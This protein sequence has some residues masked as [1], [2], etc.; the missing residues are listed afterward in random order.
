MRS[1]YHFYHICYLQP[2]TPMEQLQN[3][4]TSA[5]SR[6]IFP[7]K[8]DVT[9][10]TAAP[11]FTLGMTPK[12]GQFLYA[13]NISVI[14]SSYKSNQV[15]A[16]GAQDNGNLACFPSQF[17]RPM[18][19]ALSPRQE[20]LEIWVGCQSHLVRCCAAPSV[21][22]EATDQE[23][24]GGG[25]FTATLVPRQLHAT[26]AHDVHGIYPFIP[27]SPLYISTLFSALCQL[28]TTK[29]EE[30]AHVL[31]KPSFVSELRAEDRCHVNGVC[32]VRC[33]DG[34]QAHYATCLSE[35]DAFDGWRNHRIQ[36]GVVVDMRTNE[37]IVRGL[38]MPHSPSWHKE[39]L[40]LLNSGTGE[41]G[42]ID[43]DTRSFV[44][45]IFIPGF[46]RGLQFHGR[47]AIVGA[48]L[49]RHAERFQDLE[50]GKTLEKKKISATCGVY[51]V[52][53]A[54]WT[55]THLI[56]FTGGV[57]EIY[58]VLLVPGRRV[59]IMG[60]NDEEPKKWYNVTTT[61]HVNKEISE[62]EKH[63]DYKAPAHTGISTDVV[64]SVIDIQ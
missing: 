32:W 33:A 27:N 4:N 22:N 60:I 3:D 25:N 8:L 52:D 17:D 46:L 19:L 44:S 58:D 21:Y 61:E 53:M 47:Y 13:E 12:V 42:Y 37:I 55:I 15:F 49:S 63:S 62:K 50:L 5:P 38:S 40:W 1:I 14:V 51:F 34:M 30:N 18:A 2:S 23:S 48:S 16:F 64:P 35:A 10:P 6:I 39:K 11:P 45:K 57:Q 28:D 26:G 20:C 56:E 41:L 59:R 9:T 24:G 43:F 29:P 31:W 36:G 54:S 7:S